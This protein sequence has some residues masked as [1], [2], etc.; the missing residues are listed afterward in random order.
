MFT[1]VYEVANE[2]G[3]SYKSMQLII[4]WPLKHRICCI[5]VKKTNYCLFKCYFLPGF[6]F[7]RGGAPHLKALLST[8]RRGLLY[9]LLFM[10]SS[11]NFGVTQITCCPFQY[12]TIFI[13]CNVDMMSVWEMLV[14]WLKDNI[15]LFIMHR[16]RNTRQW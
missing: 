6:T 4:H 8:V 3:I 12:L 7:F 10:C 9:W 11:T 16:Y 5:S 15:L 14:I 1:S 13:L 2:I